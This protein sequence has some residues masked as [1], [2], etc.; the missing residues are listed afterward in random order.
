M[1][2][3]SFDSVIQNG[4][5]LLTGYD[6]ARRARITNTVL[7]KIFVMPQGASQGIRNCRLVPTQLLP[8]ART[9]VVTATRANS[10][11]TQRQCL[12][13]QTLYMLQNSNHQASPSQ[14]GG[15]FL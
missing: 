4:Y 14:Y 15:E 12:S 5:A 8:I 1:T 7:K 9:E 13:I 11:G 2:V 3:P 6:L 10:Y